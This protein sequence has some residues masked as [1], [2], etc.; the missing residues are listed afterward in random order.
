MRSATNTAM[1]V[2]IGMALSSANAIPTQIK[3]V[4]GTKTRPVWL[5]VVLIAACGS[6]PSWR[7]LR[8]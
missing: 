5:I 7:S 8:T 1:K 6:A 2:M 3:S 4:V